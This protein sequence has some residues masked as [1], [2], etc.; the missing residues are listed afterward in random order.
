MKKYSILVLSIFL[1]S[2]CGSSNLKKTNQDKVKNIFGSNVYMMLSIG[3]SNNDY[4]DHLHMF[5]DNKGN[6]FFPIY[7]SRKKILETEMIMPDNIAFNGILVALTSFDDMTYKINYSLTDEIIIKGKELKKILK[8]EI[9]EL[10]KNN[11]DIMEGVI[12]KN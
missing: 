10:K 4:H 9:E 8:S 3:K 1:F 2:N 11:P 5:K 12:L 6:P 7:T